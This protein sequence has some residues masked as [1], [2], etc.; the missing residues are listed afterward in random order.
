MGR[1]L[2]EE[3][4]GGLGPTPES[5]LSGHVSA[6]GPDGHSGGEGLGDGAAEGDADLLPLAEYIYRC[7]R[8]RDEMLGA[9]FFGEPA[10]DILLDLFIGQ[11]RKPA[12]PLGTSSANTVL[13][14]QNVLEAKG[15]VTRCTDAASGGNHAC[16]TDKGQALMRDYLRRAARSTGKVNI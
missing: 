13:R 2:G 14:W 15:L 12:A 1:K 9:D 7:R 4:F 11:S 5:G 8:I 3:G 6:G 16:L 10:W